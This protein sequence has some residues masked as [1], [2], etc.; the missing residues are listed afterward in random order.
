MSVSAAE[1]IEK[2]RGAPQINDPR[3]PAHLIKANTFSEPTG[4]TT[5]LAFYDLELGAKLLYP[6]LTPLR[7]TIPRLSG[8]GGTQ[9][10]W[11]AI[12]AINNTGVRAGVSEAHRGGII[13]VATKD[14]AAN[15][16]GIGIESSVSFEATYAAQGFDDVRALAAQT[17]LQSL[18]L[19]EEAMILGGNSS[20][21]LG[22]PGAVTLSA[23]TTGGTLAAQTWSVI[24]VP[25]AHDGVINA[26]VAGGIQQ[27]LNRTNADGS[28]DTFGGGAGFKSGATTVATT[29][30]A[31]S[32]TASIP[33]IQGALGYAWFWGAAGAEVLGAI[34]TINSVSITAAATGTQTAAT[35]IAYSNGATDYSVN[36]LAFDGLL[37]QA[38]VNGSGS[39]VKYL[40]PGT[41]G[42]GTPLTADGQGGI[43]EIDAALKWFWDNFRL[44]PDTIWVNSQEAL[45]ISRKILQSA[46]NGAQ[47]FVFNTDQSM[48]GGGV[49]VRT[50]LNRFSMSGPSTLD[51]RIHPNMPAG[52]I[53]MTTSTLPYP[54]SNVANVMQIRCRQDYFQI[55]WPITSRNYPYG[56]YADEVLQHYFPPSMGVIT[57][58]ANG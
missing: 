5:G 13:G 16:K 45:N 39:Y 1:I 27:S 55:Q 20:L 57:N 25:L 32:I 50:Y 22:Q 40:D 49:M 36:N 29:S 46:A 43:V 51:I 23:S 14:Y 28:A 58:I 17:G 9:A 53:L 42:I 31:S 12:T 19:Q 34:S 7:N 15:Y 26:S 38:L 56:V 11:R 44:S 10:A 30:A 4:P 35:L 41:A 54:L 6:V 33:A 3:M 37:T 18:M 24:A 2:L 47:R 52:T 48:I 8:K 21:P